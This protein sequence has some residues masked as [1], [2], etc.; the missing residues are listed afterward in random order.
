[1]ADVELHSRDLGEFTDEL[2]AAIKKFNKCFED[3]EN[4]I[5]RLTSAPFMGEAAEALKKRGAKSVIAY[6]TH[7]VLSGN[8]YSNIAE[9]QIDSLV[10][11]DSIPASEK[12]KKLKNF[13][14]LSL[15][16]M[17]AEAIRRINNEESISAMFEQH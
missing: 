4:E 12:F 11:S 8:A 9:S 10:V 2:G 7:A 17:L 14:E 3:L 5:N 15:A 13:R 1:M 6:G 16:S